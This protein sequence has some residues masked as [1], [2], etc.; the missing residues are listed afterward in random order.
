MKSFVKTSGATGLHIFI[1]I[2]RKYE[3]GQVRA[4][5]EIVALMASERENG[6]LTRTFRVQDRPKNT[7]F[8]DVRQNASE[9]SLAAIFSLRPREGAPVSTPLSWEELKEGLQPQRWNI[10]TALE[11]L[12][13]RAKLWR[14]FWKYPQRIEDAVEALEK[15]H[16]KG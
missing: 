13:E 8:F 15:A 14:D 4:L 9:Q 16:G 3:F 5:L 1:P 11:D 12:P 2:E 10:K 6:L 7:V